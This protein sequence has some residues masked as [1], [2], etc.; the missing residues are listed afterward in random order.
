MNSKHYKQS[1]VMVW[2]LIMQYVDF[3]GFRS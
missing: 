3:S 1:C 2:L